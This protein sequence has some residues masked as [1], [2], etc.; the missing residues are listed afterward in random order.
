[1]LKPILIS[2]FL[3]LPEH[4]SWCILQP[5]SVM[6]LP[7]SYRTNHQML[8]KK[9]VSKCTDWINPLRQNLIAT[10]LTQ[11]PIFMLRNPHSNRSWFFTLSN[12]S[13]L[14]LLGSFPLIWILCPT[15]PHLW[16]FL[17]LESGCFSNACGGQSLTL[18]STDIVIYTNHF[19]HSCMMGLMWLH[20]WYLIWI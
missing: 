5:F 9:D 8:K 10:L 19:I 3:P 11:F 2:L 14:V 16:T 17:F 7:F 15:R 12:D 18:K 20:S 1:M 6:Q 13:L 4:F